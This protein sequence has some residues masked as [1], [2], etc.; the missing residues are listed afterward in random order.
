MKKP[1]LIQIEKQETIDDWDGFSGNLQ[2]EAAYIEER[3]KDCSDFVCRRFM[4]GE[5]TA[6]LCYLDGMTSSDVINGQILRSLMIDV[7]IAGQDEE[8]AEQLEPFLE[9][10]T[11]PIGELDQ[12]DTW[13][14]GLAAIYVGDSLL[15]IDQFCHGFVLNTKGFPQRSVEKPGS[16]MVLRGPEEAFTET[17]R[18]N[19][20]LLRKR[21]KTTTLKMP[22]MTLG[23]VTKTQVLVIYLQGVANEEVVAE[24]QR[25][26]SE[27][28]SKQSIME[29]SCVEQFIEDNPY[30]VFPQIQ[31]TERPDRVCEAL[32]EGRVAIM[33]DGS[34]NVLLVPTLLFQLIQAPDDYY[35]RADAGTFIR[36][37]RY[38]GTAIALLLPSLYVAITS[39][40][41]EMLPLNLLLSIAAAR[42]GVPF[43]AFIEALFMALSFELLREASLRM[44][45][46]IGSTIGIVGALVIGEAAVSA[47]LVAPQMVVVVAI[48]AIGSFTLPS[49][50]VSYSVRLLRF[51]LLLLAAVLGLYGVMLGLIAIVIHLIHLKSFGYAYLAP[52]APFSLSG[53]KEMLFRQERKKISQRKLFQYPPQFS[54]RRR[55]DG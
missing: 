21:L 25:R 23:Q 28:Q 30:S 48:T 8:A 31:Y 7:R 12:V 34:P 16:E 52:L 15:L 18:V 55:R 54:V 33:V 14:D 45:T 2:Q 36:S 32:V 22:A 19:T 35:N 39:F 51:P 20:A 47:N 46:V 4:I 24:A 5:R 37:I 26:L 27:L 13:K 41:P 11:L 53:M 49:V 17:L 10:H 42:E 1:K 50:E 38:M 3:F 43:P 40:H 9:S 6:A 29:S 44:P